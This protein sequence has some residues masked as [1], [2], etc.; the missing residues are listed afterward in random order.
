METNHKQRRRNVFGEEVRLEVMAADARRS[1]AI[2]RVQ[3][4][5]QMR[6]WW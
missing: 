3:A 5:R 1:A 6:N 4:P 2:V